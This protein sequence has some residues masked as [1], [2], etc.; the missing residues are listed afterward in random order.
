MCAHTDICTHA[1]TQTQGQTSQEFCPTTCTATWASRGEASRPGDWA[2]A[3]PSGYPRPASGGLSR[4]AQAHSPARGPALSQLGTGAPQRLPRLWTRA[5]HVPFSHGPTTNLSL[6]LLQKGKREVSRAFLPA[7]PG[8]LCSWEGAHPP[9]R[10][11]SLCSS[12]A[13]GLRPWGSHPSFSH[14]SDAVVTVASQHAVLRD[15]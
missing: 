10:K 6:L 3:T 15:E 14:L 2:T 4:S 1:C 8:V 11:A 9:R 5:P 12:E 7:D 13:V